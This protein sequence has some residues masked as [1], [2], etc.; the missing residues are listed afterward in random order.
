MAAEAFASDMQSVFE[1]GG[2]AAL[3]FEEV[4]LVAGSRRR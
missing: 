2:I 1:L 3:D 4:D